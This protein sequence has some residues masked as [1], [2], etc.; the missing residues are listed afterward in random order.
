MSDYFQTLE[1]AE[2]HIHRKKSIEPSKVKWCI[3]QCTMGFM[4]VSEAQ[5]YYSFP[6]SLRF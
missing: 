1:Q 3:I 6:D 5:A 2:Q 4:V